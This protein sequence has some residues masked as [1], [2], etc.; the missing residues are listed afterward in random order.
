LNFI[1]IGGGWGQLKKTF[2]FIWYY[3]C[4]FYHKIQFCNFFF[5]ENI[6]ELGVEERPLKEVMTLVSV[7]TGSLTDLVT[8]KLYRSHNFLHNFSNTRS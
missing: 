2:C 4:F 7:R 6:V 1:L 3:I 8:Y 5:I